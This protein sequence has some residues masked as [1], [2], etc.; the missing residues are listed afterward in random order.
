VCEAALGALVLA[1]ASDL[2]IRIGLRVTA[3]ALV[4][5]VAAL[6]LGWARLIPVSL[7]L[8]GGAYA[9]YLGVDDV[10]VDPAAPAL[11]AGLVVT[12]ELAY[13]SLEEAQGIRPAAGEV[14]RR[15]A[16]VAGLGLGALILS[17]GVLALA[18][19]ASTRGLA[20]D[21]LGAMA[22]AAALILVVALA[23][24]PAGAP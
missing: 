12:A 14:W 16:F 22:A 1:R 3:V 4:V 21:L 2:V 20:I 9:T 10:A 11:A 15:A 18:D 5:L 8:L 24:R 17:G 23:R 13:L 7:L 6:V 19:A